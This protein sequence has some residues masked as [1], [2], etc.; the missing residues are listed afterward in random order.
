MAV[1]H[2]G[3]DGAKETNDEGEVDDMHLNEYPKGWS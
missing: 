2:L 1:Q 3:M